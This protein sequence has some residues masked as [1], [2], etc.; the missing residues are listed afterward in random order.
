[1]P[2]PAT[3]Q[4]K[5]HDVFGFASL[6]EGQEPVL[7]HLLAGKSVLAIFPTGGGKN[8]CYQLPP[9]EF[10]GHTP[11]V[12]PPIALIKDPPHFL[13]NKSG[14]APRIDSTPGGAEDVNG[15]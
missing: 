14:A 1:M 3:T 10:P 12:S 11:V 2:L 15:L 7:T 4:Q 8:L 13:K 9:L 6:R 5:L